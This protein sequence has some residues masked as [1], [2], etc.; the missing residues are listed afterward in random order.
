LKV[1]FEDFIAYAAF[2]MMI[3][4]TPRWLSKLYL[5]WNKKY[6]RTHRF[7]REV[8][9][10]IIEEEQNKQHETEHQKPKN[11]IASLVSS[12]N[13]HANDEQISSGLTRAEML[14]EVLLSIVGAYGT[15]SAALSWY[16]FFLS[17]NPRV[18]Q[19]MKEELREHNLVMT[20][21][22]ECVPSLTE[23]NLA[24]LIYCECVTKEVGYLRRFS[25]IFLFYLC[26][27]FVCLPLLV[28]PRVWQLAIQ[29]WIM[30]PFALVK[31]SSLLYTTCIRMDAI[32][33][34]LIQR[35][36]YP[37]DI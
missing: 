18:Q 29:Y 15:T 17:K 2:M 24:S 25:I 20:D 13:E 10:K 27:S 28:S 4:W 1:A 5:K 14:D 35:N 23:E 11:L 36:L 8:S 3:S 21:D 30:Y 22:A 37:S 31:R 34:M 12:L 16:I 32:G 26:R 9:E 19:R 33:I 6:Q 7:I